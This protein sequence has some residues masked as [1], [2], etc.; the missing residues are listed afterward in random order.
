M[1]YLSSIAALLLSAGCAWAEDAAFSY[2]QDG[3][4]PD[5]FGLSAGETYN[6]AILLDQPAM[7]GKT[8]KS[9]SVPLS[10]DDDAD[11]KAWLTTTLKLKTQGGKKVN[12]ADLC[13]VEATWADGVLTAAFPE[14]MTVPE[15]GLYVGYTFTAGR[16]SQTPVAVVPHQGANC[17]WV[18]STNSQLKWTDLGAKNDVAS[19][20]DVTLSGD[21]PLA[22]Y[23]TLPAVDYMEAAAGSTVTAAI[24][25]QGTTAVSSIGYT[26][27]IDGNELSG[28]YTLPQAI[29]AQLGYAAQV[30]LPV[31]AIEQPGKSPLSLSITSV[32]GQD[33]IYKQAARGTLHIIPFVPVNRPLTEEYT[34]LDCSWCTRGYVMMEQMNLEYGEDFVA[35]A[36][37]TTRYENGAMS[38]VQLNECPQYPSGF[39]NSSVNRGTLSD[40][41]NIRSN[42]LKA[43]NGIPMG[44][45][46]AS[47]GWA[48]E[49]K[50]ALA[51][52]ISA[53]FI[54]DFDGGTYKLGYVLVADSVSNPTWGQYN[55][56]ASAELAE[57]DPQD[58]TTPFW[59][60]FYLTTSP[61]YGLVFNDVN[62]AKEGIKGVEGALPERIAMDEDYAYEF[63]VPTASLVNARDE[64]FVNDFGKTR[65]L[66]FII[67]AKSGKIVNAISSGYT[68]GQPRSGVEDVRTEAQNGE[69]AY[70]DLAGHRV[71]APTHGIYIKLQGGKAMKV[72]L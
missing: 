42:W 54:D 21:F 67:E 55:S 36:Y 50:D 72:K 31:Q 41:K 32:N 34:G 27:Q 51:C 52:R 66:A 16:R 15:G 47:I 7:I 56:Y 23:A 10:Q 71:N 3:Q 58:F 39:P 28:T 30:S 40:P 63:E 1:K 35:V 68:D 69:A 2:N 49:A 19:A 62:L 65:L 70:Y 57:T 18:A 6:V 5:Q 44:Q 12:V 29:P 64:Q 25:N 26:C 43:R 48:N 46:A 14:G 33:N 22:A 17:L 38:T 60:L 61:V 45:P 24:V 59:D 8:V 13:T 11:C 20:M 9:L 53:R 37:H 4:M